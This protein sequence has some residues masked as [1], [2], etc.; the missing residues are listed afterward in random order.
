MGFAVTPHPNVPGHIR[1]H[2]DF[3][4][5]QGEIPCFY[6]EATLAL[7]SGNETAKNAGQEEAE[8]APGLVRKDHR[9]HG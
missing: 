7:P 1:T 9:T 8:T 6:L 3:V 5:L 4:V 2:P